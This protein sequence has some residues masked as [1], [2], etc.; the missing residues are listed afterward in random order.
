MSFY[1]FYCCHL[2]DRATMVL[3]RDRANFDLQMSIH[4]NH[5]VEVCLANFYSI[6]YQFIYSR[7][8]LNKNYSATSSNTNI[9]NLLVTCTTTARAKS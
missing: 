1:L 5:S 4:V 6:Y 9:Y 8:E 3:P 2:Q 7:Q